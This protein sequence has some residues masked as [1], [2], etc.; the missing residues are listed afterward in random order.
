MAE[1]HHPGRPRVRCG[2]AVAEAV[3]ATLDSGEGRLEEE[4]GGWRR[5]SAH[6]RARRPLP[7]TESATAL[8]GRAAAGL[9][10]VGG[11]C[12]ESNCGLV[13]LGRRGSAFP[14]QE[15]LGHKLCMRRGDRR[16]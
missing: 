16:N 7:E 5:K 8:R 14:G 4:A 13:E 3:G 11:L 9:F 10:W 2:V 1:G 12:S 6:R 15:T